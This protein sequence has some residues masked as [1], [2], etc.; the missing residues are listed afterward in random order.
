MRFEV[1]EIMKQA[2]VME[3]VYGNS[4]SP[5]DL[6]GRHYVK[7]GQVI[8]ASHP[9]AVGVRVLDDAGRVF[10]MDMVERQPVFALFLPEREP[11]SYQIEMTFR[12][13]NTFT[14]YDP[15]SFP[16]Q[17]TEKE[18]KDFM[19]G[20]WLNAYRKMGCHLVTIGGVKGLY[21][22]VW[23]PSARRVSVVGDFNFWNGLIYPMHRL[24]SSGIFELFVPGLE[25]GR[26]YRFEVKTMSGEVFQKVDPCSAVLQGDVSRSVDFAEFAWEDA[27]WMRNRR[28][29]NLKGI[30]LAVCDVAQGS[31]LSEEL[32]QGDFTHILFSHNTG[33]KEEKEGY[34][35]VEGF[36]HVP[37]CGGSA[38]EFRRVINEAHRNHV[39]VLMEVSPEYYCRDDSGL[40]CFDGTS[41]Y[42]FADDRI[43]VDKKR[44]MRRYD[45]HKPEVASY[46]YSGMVYW[47]KEFHID[48]FVFEGVSGV[49][50]PEIN[51]TSNNLNICSPE[52]LQNL[53]AVNR[54]FLKGLLSVVHQTDTSI[55]TIADEKA[56]ESCEEEELFSLKNGFDYVWNYSVKKSVDYYF[57]CDEAERK[58]EY[59]RLT[60]PLQK[61]GLENS[62][63]VLNAKEQTFGESSIDNEA[64]VDYDKRAEAKMS[65]AFLLGVP[66]RKVWEEKGT[67]STLREYIRSLLKIYRKY[68]T[69]HEYDI[70]EASFEWINSV[71]AQSGVVS[72]IRKTASGRNP[73]LFV[74]NFS[75]C[76]QEEYRIGVPRY[77]RYIL[78]S[79][80]DDALYGG[81]GR[82]GEQCPVS[83]RK[84]CDFRPFSISISLPPMSTLIF[85]YVPM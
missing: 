12:D 72:F 40:K 24:G 62:L 45:L 49:L 21:F 47:M 6:L 33:G 27:S 19:E 73:L 57:A 53:S 10:E 56:E 18:E 61:A 17:I 59:F 25:A 9:D 23:A 16:S 22:A 66:G 44:G 4:A 60:L 52:G 78:I 3:L 85:E 28:Y 68:P 13:G 20:R 51:N 11:F 30:P 31:H 84:R 7:G 64:K 29:K 14:S 26:P 76:A 8:S 15:Y 74:S 82:F 5:K 36:Y 67:D 69:F 1:S 63:L 65:A 55:L 81:E 2:Q 32:F 80:S 58:K 75:R 35:A 79:N 50:T 34:K 83:V 42:G 39:G 54:E 48:G 46:I 71:D 43:G 37:F 77:G 38:D 70:E 41:L